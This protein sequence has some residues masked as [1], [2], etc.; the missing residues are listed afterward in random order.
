MKLSRK[1]F[2]GL[3]KSKLEI[4]DAF[5]ALLSE[6]DFQKI[7]IQQIAQKADVAR[8]TVYNHFKSKEDIL[9]CY[10]QCMTIE[11]QQEASH[12]VDPTICDLAY[13]A[14]VHWKKHHEFIHVLLRN[15]IYILVLDEFIRFFKHNPI[16]AEA[17]RVF[18]AQFD[19]R[20]MLDY[21]R[22]FIASGLWMLLK[23]WVENGMQESPLEMATSYEKFVLR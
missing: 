8:A 4:V 21:H 19:N 1:D 5:I 3:S 23:R 14:F 11:Y 12:F 10:I 17:E 15:D 2:P 7:T 6:Y 22:D 9:R 18:N 13:T 16:E 20:N